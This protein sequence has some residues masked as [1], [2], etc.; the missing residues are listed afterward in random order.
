MAEPTA[1]PAG[2]AVT[3][4]F[5]GRRLLYLGTGALGVMFMPMWVQWLRANYP[6]LRV[7]P[8]LTRSAT[9]FVSRTAVSLFAGQP[10]EL[11]DWSGAA[12]MVAPHVEMAAWADAIIVHPAT[13]HF[14]S[15]FAVGLADT[16][17]LLALQ[18]FSGPIAV[19]SAFPPGGLASA[20]WTK[21]AA[22]LSGR[23]NVTMVAP[24]QGVSLTTGKPEATTAA[25]LNE[26]IPALEDL[27][28]KLAAR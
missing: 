27:R 16:P 6:D 7:R 22:E 25:P 2:P 23:P 9:R 12:E 18:C 20:A 1:T 19:A 11:D 21:H 5:G 13:F 17:T 28:L 4:R 3:P 10:A 24:H 14:V 8:V 26:V 15:R